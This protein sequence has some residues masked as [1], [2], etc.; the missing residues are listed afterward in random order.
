MIDDFRYANLSSAVNLVAGATNFL[1]GTTLADDWVYQATNIVMGAGQNYLGS[2]FTSPSG[3][4]GGSAHFPDAA[5]TDR[6]YM[7]VNALVAN[8][9]VPEPSIIMLFGLGLL[10]LGFT[11]RRKA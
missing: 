2:Y 3:S 9:S 7:T 4:A 5:A 8:A 1:A 10:G 11:R 6:Q